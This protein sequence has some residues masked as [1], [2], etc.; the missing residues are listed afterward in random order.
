MAA[1]FDGNQ[2]GSYG[3][4]YLEAARI[5]DPNVP[6]WVTLVDRML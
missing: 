6:P 3:I 1:G 2:S 4:G 5:Y